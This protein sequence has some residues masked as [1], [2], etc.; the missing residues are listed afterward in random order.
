MPGTVIR[1]NP[2]SIMAAIAARTI[3]SSISG[4]SGRPAA[5]TLQNLIQIRYLAL[6]KVLMS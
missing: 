5:S 1:C 2:A 6:R 4:S 3:A